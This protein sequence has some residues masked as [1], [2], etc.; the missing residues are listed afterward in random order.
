M[1]CSNMRKIGLAG[2]HH[3]TGQFLRGV[4]WRKG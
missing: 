1:E 4:K 3:F 2:L